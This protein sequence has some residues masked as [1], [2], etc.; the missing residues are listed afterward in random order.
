MN[1]PDTTTFE[2]ERAKQIALSNASLIET[3]NK[4]HA[5]CLACDDSVK[6]VVLNKVKIAR[7]VGERLQQVK[8]DLPHGRWLSWIRDNLTFSQDTARLYIRFFEA[9]REPVTDLDKGI[10][11]LK[12]A[13]I[14][15]GALSS[16]THGKQTATNLSWVDKF[17]LKL[18]SVRE[19]FKTR[20]ERVPLEKWTPKER[21]N[22]KNY[23]QPLVVIY[24]QL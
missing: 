2:E 18:G 4:G 6:D 14:A 13:M 5:E 16:P 10:D 7:E 17:I 3:I 19:S 21:E 23:L 22:A 11:S 15:C 1:T 8:A 20:T 24:E 9:N 12:D